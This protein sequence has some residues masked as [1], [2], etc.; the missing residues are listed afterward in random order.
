MTQVTDE[1]ESRLMDSTVKTN[2]YKLYL[3]KEQAR[4]ENRKEAK[5]LFDKY[6]YPGF[7]MVGKEGSRQFWSIVNQEEND[8]EFQLTVLDSMILEVV[9]ANA[10]AE[11]YAQLMDRA[12]MKSNVQ[13]LYG[14]QFYMDTITGMAISYP[15]YDPE[16]VDARREQMNLPSLQEFLS[17]EARKWNANH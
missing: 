2:K 11:D 3:K 7:D 13:Q 16:N 12:R 1:L 9:E 15:M 5:K 8:L 14:T 4:S 17:E 10:Y 6:G